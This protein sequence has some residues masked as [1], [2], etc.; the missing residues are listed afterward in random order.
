MR[1]IQLCS[2]VIVDSG[3]EVVKQEGLKPLFIEIHA[4]FAEG[5]NLILILLHFGQERADIVTT[6]REW[7][8]LKLLFFLMMINDE[9]RLH[10]GHRDL[11]E[12]QT[13]NNITA[14]NFV[15]IQTD[16]HLRL[17]GDVARPR[18]VVLE[19]EAK[20]PWE[21]MELDLL[22]INNAFITRFIGVRSLD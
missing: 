22:P 2:K 10:H 21:S 9:L 11:E 8:I 17:E 3:E 20:I 12:N 14:R 15:R 13:T 16:V 6:Q 7:Y 19:D 1:K 4:V 5:I 18:D